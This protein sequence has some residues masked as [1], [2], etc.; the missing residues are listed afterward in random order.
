MTQQSELWKALPWKQFRE[1]TFRLQKRIYEASR[2]NDIERVIHLQKFLFKSYGARMLAIRQVTQLNS[3]KKM[4][5]I[6]GI[7]FLTPKQRFLLEQELLRESTK[8]KHMGARKISI[9][10]PDGST[11][12]LKIPTIRDRAWQC[13]VKLVVEPAHEAKFN[14]RSYGFR[15][16]RCAHDAQKV[17]F[18]NLRSNSNGKSKRILELDIEKC[19]DRI[20]HSTIMD[21]IIAP[22]FIKIGLYKCLKAGVDP[23][24]PDQGTPQG[25]VISPL[26]ANIALNGIEDIHRSV[27]YADDMI[28]FLKPQD[29]EDVIL[30]NIKK[31]LAQ[32]GMN[33]KL[34]KTKITQ[35]T[36]GFD[37]LGWHF[38]N[39]R[40]GKF[41]CH[42]SKDNFVNFKKKVKN[43]INNSSIK[44]NDRISKITPVVRGWRNYHIYCD[45]SKHDLWRLD[46][47]VF[48]K[49]LNNK[50]YSKDD[51]IKLVR[52]AF[53]KVGYLTNRF[54]NVK[55]DK[56]PYDGNLDYWRKRKGKIYNGMTAKL[57]QIQSYTC[58]YCN[59]KDCFMTMK[60][61]SYIILMVTMTIGHP[62]I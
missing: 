30:S 51:S 12:T 44:I 26:L 53:P 14:A 34:S 25:G 1:D 31:F 40:S 3:G 35:T 45:M 48:K 42:P 47:Y 10:K 20:N 15:P 17:I 18:L 21:N 49:I 46:N 8:W 32:R 50:S 27:R 9:P 7:S 6:D 41:I 54:I 56:S 60:I 5:G 36:C 57:L 55:H 58:S 23:Y 22:R 4:A 16:G 11:R 24:F 52:K 39:T 43:L 13:L 19:F 29:N 2:N 37:F 38:V 28:F 59:L 61:Y 62:K 33:I